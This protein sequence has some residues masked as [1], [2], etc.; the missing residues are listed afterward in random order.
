MSF[1]HDNP[2]L[3]NQLLEA[4]LDSEKKLSKQG[5]AAPVQKQEQPAVSGLKSI[6]NSLRDQITP[7]TGPNDISH[8]TG[9]ADVF[10]H[11]L[12]SMGDLIQW[13]ASNGTKIGAKAIVY[14]GNQQRPSEEYGYFKIEP[15]TEILVADSPARPDRGNVAVVG[16]WINPT[17]LKNYLISLQAD[18]KLKNNVMF[19]VQLLKLIQDANKQLDVDISEQ[20]KEPE[21]TLPD[22]TLVDNTPAELDPTQY[23]TQGN[24]PLTLGDLNSSMALNSWLNSKK[25]GLK[26]NGHS[27]AMAINHPDFDHCALLKILNQ[28]ATF[29]ARRAT[30]VDA[31][32]VATAYTQKVKAIATEISCDLGGQQP[33][34]PGQQPGQQPGQG[35]LASAS[36]QVL[37]QLSALQPFDSQVISFQEIEEFLKLYAQYANDANVSQMINKLQF[38]IQAFKNDTQMGSDTIPMYNLTT[39]QFKGMLKNPAKAYVDASL[40]HDIVFYG[41]TLYQRLVTS[42]QSIANDPERG[43]YINYRAMQQ[44]VTPGGPQ[45]T[46]VDQINRLMYSF[47]QAWN[48][49]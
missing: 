12:D 9:G 27:G 31:K 18:P 29:N 15:G 23:S 3:V 16:Y 42:L 47:R 45:Q 35:G 17:A 33:Q 10:S 41:G 6:L 48:E 46:N 4:A 11:N 39:E 8:E 24:I 25:V 38:S 43:K 21:K 36:P 30:S 32:A 19:Q 14:P 13:L 20:Y 28:R 44:Q 49:K 22:N 7:G 40:L 37:M 1:I 34:K 5:Q 26:I 2:W